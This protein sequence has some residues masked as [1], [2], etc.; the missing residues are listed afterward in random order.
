MNLTVFG[1]SGPTGRLVVGQ[2]LA[3]G[4]H[5]SGVTRRPDEYPLRSPDLDVV[6]ADVTDRAGVAQALAG[7]EAVISTFGVPYSRR[8]ITVYSEGIVTITRA[9]T[10]AGIGRLVCVSSTTVA[11][12]DAPGDSLV[13]RRLVRPLLRHFVGRTLYDDM[14]HMEAIVRSSDLDWTVVRPGGLFTAAQPTDDYEVSP[15]RLN[16]RIT[17]RADLAD[18]LLQEAT[19]P[20]HSRAVIEVITRSGTPSP[21]TFLKEVLGVRT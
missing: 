16:G 1:A 19:S 3:A 5:V 2:A 7:A 21:F 20:Q 14:Q 11:T 12:D 4:H 10:D 18:A 8:Q 17:S 15:H 6:A 13:S 9:M